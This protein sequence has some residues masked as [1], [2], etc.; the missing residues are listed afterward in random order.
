M[1]RIFSE[2]M[3]GSPPN[4]VFR[5]HGVGLSSRQTPRHLRSG[6][7]R[8]PGGFAENHKDTNSQKISPGFSECLGH[9]NGSAG[10]RSESRYSIALVSSRLGGSISGWTT[11]SRRTITSAEPVPPDANRAVRH[12][13][14]P[15]VNRLRFCCSGKTLCPRSSA[16]R[17]SFHASS[18]IPES[19]QDIQLI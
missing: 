10:T 14:I 18:R 8:S 15:W 19:P 1:P 17:Q 13:G 2:N 5:A 6:G 7:N 12:P 4:I 9:S 16:I 11:R 3:G